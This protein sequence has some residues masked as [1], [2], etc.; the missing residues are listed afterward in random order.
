MMRHHSKSL[1]LF[2]LAISVLFASGSE[3][4]I[5]VT[6]A[7]R[8]GGRDDAKFIQNNMANPTV[9]DSP[10]PC[11]TYT[12]PMAT[13][14]QLRP[15][16]N[17]TF[18]VQETINH[19]GRFFVQF[20][21]DATQNFWTPANQLARVEDPLV[22]GTTPLSIVV[23]NTP[24]DACMI[25]VL[26]QMD[27]QPGEFYVQCYDVRINASNPVATPPAGGPSTLSANS[28]FQKPG[29]GCAMISDSSKPP[30]SGGP[31]GTGF[32]ALITL[33]LM[34]MPLVVAVERRLRV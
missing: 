23:P 17:F 9:A 31:G 2:L 26:Q 20:R 32:A 12:T 3:A 15:G 18:T 34:L 11:S 16:Q 10:S 13:R 19:P 27:E 5:I 4:H 29:F 22:R 30:G 1:S 28:D 33:A 6:P 7:N 14:L 21:Q 24:C 8:M 25:R